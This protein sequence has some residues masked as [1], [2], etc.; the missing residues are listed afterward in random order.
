MVKFNPENKEIL[1]FG[2]CLDPTA[3]ISSEEEAEQ[4][5]KDYTEYVQ[6]A[7]NKNPRND[8][9][10]ALDICKIN[11]GYYSGYLDSETA[12]RVKKL[13]NCKHPIFG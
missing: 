3:E 5:L 4:Y 12:E 9:M 1:T 13:F 7:L 8:E 2:E 6:N 10:T 11:I